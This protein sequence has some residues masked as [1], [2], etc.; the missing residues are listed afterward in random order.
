MKKRKGTGVIA[1]KNTLKFH[2]T[3]TKY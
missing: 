1:G 3:E 2:I